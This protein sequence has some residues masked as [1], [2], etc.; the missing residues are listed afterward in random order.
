M[1]K[2]NVV[3][4]GSRPWLP[5]PSATNLDV[6][7]EDDVPAIGVFELDSEK[8][9]FTA[10]GGVDTELTVWAYL[11]LSPAEYFELDELTFD[12][13]PGMFRA[14]ES[15]FTGRAFIVATAMHYAL[16]LWG[17]T[18]E[19]AKGLYESSTTFLKDAV[20]ARALEMRADETARLR[21]SS[22][23]STATGQIEALKRPTYAR[24]TSSGSSQLQDFK[25]SRTAAERVLVTH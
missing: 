2:D 20:A 5:K 12:S 17:V 9:L 11:P 16:D 24:P 23:S 13:V 18:G 1:N 3:R 25:S 10:V 21:N 4:S 8:V 7:H 22:E 15:L 6:W 19:D 14:V